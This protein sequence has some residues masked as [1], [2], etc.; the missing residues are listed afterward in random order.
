MV[1]SVCVRFPFTEILRP[2]RE[3][4]DNTVQAVLQ[5]KHVLIE[6]PTGTGKTMAL[7]C[8]T[9][10]A[11]RHLCQ[12]SGAAPRII[13]CTR[14][15]RQIK[16]V[17]QQARQSPYL[18]WLQVVGSREQ[19]LCIEPDVLRMSRDLD[20]KSSEECK[21]AR[22]NANEAKATEYKASRHFLESRSVADSGSR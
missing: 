10:A 15:H 1:R 12:S 14:T 17:V 19:G 18:P 21:K 7:L 4:I 16:Q 11:Q 20:A 2:Q 22:R 3:I 6:S 5:G 13:F 9:L 8:G